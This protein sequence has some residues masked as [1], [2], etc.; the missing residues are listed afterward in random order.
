MV[1]ITVLPERAMSWTFSITLCAL[2]ESSPEVGSSKN[3]SD[4]PWIMSTPIETRLR[5]PPDIPRV[6]SSP[7]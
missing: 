6:P 4:G 1:K 2:V 3:S 7:M 5:S